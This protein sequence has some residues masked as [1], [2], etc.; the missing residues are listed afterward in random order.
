VKAAARPVP[1]APSRGQEHEFEPQFGLP[2]RLPADERILWQGQPL[3]GLVAK[4]VFHLHWIS[5]YF[6]LMLAWQFGA[7]IADGAGF[8]AAL[9]GSLVLAL[10]AATAIAILATMARLTASTTAY[11]LTNRR[12]VMRIGIVLTVSYNLP[13]RHIDGA[14]LLP[15]KDGTGE[16]ALQLRG[17]T[18]IAWLHLWPHA[19]PWMLA[20]PQPMLRCL[21]DAPAVAR[22]LSDAWAL[23]N[24]MPAQPAHVPA[25]QQGYAGREQMA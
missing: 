3:P 6:A 23:A 11:T 8:V 9:R 20:R 12:V 22:Q 17:D 4:R 14:H 24:A 1:K 25:P 2:E 10:L 15:L 19:R 13:L 7:Q 5:G 21:A 18:R 16:L